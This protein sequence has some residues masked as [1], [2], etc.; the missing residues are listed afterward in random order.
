ML[1]SDDH[2]SDDYYTHIICFLFLPPYYSQM[3]ITHASYERGP[4]ILFKHQM[5]NFINFLA[6]S[7]VAIIIIVVIFITC[8]SLRHLYLSIP[9]LSGQWSSSL[10]KMKQ[11]TLSLS[12]ILLK[13][14]IV[15]TV[16]MVIVVI[17]QDGKETA[18]REKKN[19]FEKVDYLG[20][21]QNL[22]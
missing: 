7:A 18:E 6:T 11:L 14:E 4:L 1:F 3:I 21:M 16:T 15:L 20:S 2:H 12:L 5:P 9:P 17:S 8:K 10:H 22:Q 13:H 19:S